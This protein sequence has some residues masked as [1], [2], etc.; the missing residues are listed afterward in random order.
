MIH[1]F[2]VHQKLLKSSL[3]AI[4]IFLHWLHFLLPIAGPKKLPLL[5]V[6]NLLSYKQLMTG[7]IFDQK[8]DHEI[9]SQLSLCERH[10][11][12]ITGFPVSWC[13]NALSLASLAKL[14]SKQPMVSE[15][16]SENFYRSYD[17]AVMRRPLIGTLITAFYLQRKKWGLDE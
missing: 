8:L 3:E 4:V 17:V 11:T 10:A 6:M 2:A 13:F 7:R 9:N 15:W 14:L 1:N 12:I 5:V 16:F